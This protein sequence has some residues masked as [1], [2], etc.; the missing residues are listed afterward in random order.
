MYKIKPNYIYFTF[1]LLVFLCIN[2]YYGSIPFLSIPTLGQAVWTSGFAKSLSHNSFLLD[3]FAR[4]IGY[5]HPAA[6]AFGLSGAWIQSLFIRLGFEPSD[7]YAM[8]NIFWLA[9]AYLGCIK[10]ARKF[11]VPKISQPIIVAVW[12]S[13]PVIS[14]HLGYSMLSLGIA[15]LPTYLYAAICLDEAETEHKKRFTIVSMLYISLT[16]IAVFMDGYTFVMFACASSFI[17]LNSIVKKRND[18]KTSTIKLLVHSFSFL[19]SYILY[20]SFIGKNSYTPSNEDYFRSWGLDLSFMIIPTIGK[21]WIL[22]LFGYSKGR[23]ESLYFG[24]SSVWVSS[25]CLPLILVGSYAFYKIK[26][27]NK[28]LIPLMLIALLSF[29]M[30]MGPSVKIDNTRTNGQE[31]LKAAPTEMPASSALMPTGNAIISKLPGFN[32]MRAAYRWLALSLA[33]FWLMFVIMAGKSNK[34]NNKIIIVTCLTLIFL[35]IPNL[36]KVLTSKKL[37]KTMLNSIDNDFISNII[38]KTSIGERVVFLPIGN[39]FLINYVAPM[40]GLKAYNIGGDKNLEEAKKSWPLE[41]R[42]FNASSIEGRV[43]SI[44]SMILKGEVD[45]VIIPYVD[46]LWSAHVW[47]CKAL[48]LDDNASKINNDLN[49]NDIPADSQCPDHYREMYAPLLKLI[50]QRPTLSVSDSSLFSIIRLNG[51]YKNESSRNEYLSSNIHK[52]NY[53]LSFTSDNPDVTF[54]MDGTWHHLEK[55]QVWTGK[56]F[57]ITLPVPDKCSHESCEAEIKMKAFAASVEKPFILKIRTQTANSLVQKTIT[58]EDNEINK[59]LIPISKEKT[60][61]VEFSV[62]QATSP[63]ILGMS[64]DARVLGMAVSEVSLIDEESRQIRMREIKK[65]LAS[66]NYPILVTP[67]NKQIKSILLGQWHSIENDRVWSG[68]DFSLL[69]PEKDSCNQQACKL[70]ISFTMFNASA[71]HPAK[72]SVKYIDQTGHHI[73]R[74]VTVTDSGLQKIVLSPKHDGYFKI[75][76]HSDTA[77]SPLQL[78]LS[79]DSRTLGMALKEVEIT[80]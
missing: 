25:F 6:I 59:I 62:P 54:L 27:S 52:F 5:P 21:S 9:I 57:G 37:Y 40:S 4:D 78:G 29:Y 42:N 64:D 35:N 19:F 41:I 48:L 10:L 8:M 20:V 50:S 53:P 36:N 80:Q 46:M 43:S 15:L 69:L 75:N 22:D 14:Q 3:F 24:D 38:L 23:S 47:P 39:D 71:I 73:D 31:E 49:M 77:E 11:D 72:L 65:S 60:Q 2:Y 45:A 58:F 79:N 66:I 28:I 30:S 74:T 56:E 12:F 67:N 1:S 34:Q 33:C 63:S 13:M 70:T 16:I 7:A 17:I 61:H 32:A 26:S 68:K 44:K 18:W 76:F 51:N 55:D